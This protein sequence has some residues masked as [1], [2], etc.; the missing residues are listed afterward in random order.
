MLLPNTHKVK[1][2]TKRAPNKFTICQ[3]SY[4]CNQLSS[5][6]LEAAIQNLGFLLLYPVVCM[7]WKTNEKH[8]R[9]FQQTPHVQDQKQQLFGSQQCHSLEFLPWDGENKLIQG[10]Q[11]EISTHLC[12]R[13]NSKGSFHPRVE[14]RSLKGRCHRKSGALG[15]VFM[16]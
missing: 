14:V 4:W 13:A 8:L 5:G 7:L 9:L 1:S 15:V 10:D 12:M 11:R 6:A 2:Q 3:W 16:L